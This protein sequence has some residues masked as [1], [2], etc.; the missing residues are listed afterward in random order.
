MKRQ[1][2]SDM[3]YYYPLCESELDVERTARA[4]RHLPLCV[5]EW[6]KDGGYALALT[7]GG[8]DLS[9]EICEAF[10]RLGYLPPTR[11]EPPAMAGRGTSSKDRWI[12]R[13]YLRACRVQRAWL[14]RKAERA[15]EVG[16]RAT[17]ISKAGGR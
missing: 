7:G 10:M 13:G 5:V 4:I 6:V 1:K 15:R 3:S 2:T 14:A 11:F 9:W 17:A 16:Q 8:M 12:L